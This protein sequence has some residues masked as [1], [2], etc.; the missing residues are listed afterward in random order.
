MSIL[1]KSIDSGSSYFVKL[2]ILVITKDNDFRQ[3]IK[4]ILEHQYSRGDL[5]ITDEFKE[6]INKFKQTQF[7]LVI[8]QAGQN[9]LN[10]ARFCKEIRDGRIG[11]HPFPIVCFYLTRPTP[12][13]MQNVIDCGP[14]DIL[15]MPLVA[16][17]LL[18]RLDGLAR[19]RLPFVVTRNYTGPTRRKENPPG[20]EVI[21][22]IEPPNPLA[23]KI[24]R[25]SELALTKEIDAAS[26][27][28]S[29]LK[30]Q[31]QGVQLNWLAKTIYETVYR[32]GGTDSTVLA[33][34][35]E[36]KNVSQKLYNDTAQWR[37]STISD[38]TKA[39]NDIAKAIQTARGDFDVT[40][41]T[42]LV[43]VTER[44]QAEIN[45]VNG[46]SGQ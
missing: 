19:S 26:Q 41:L 1:K 34:V 7:D 32:I 12:E 40:L 24:K 9:D 16:S 33:N 39:L 44:I 42:D 17:H 3:E 21:P 6:A 18:T 45:R 29:Q 2:S 4:S 25:L 27:R 23:A 31:R 37:R 14:D 8:L 46:L 30:F 38:D 36:I 28:I 15:K 35:E 5:A 10:Y 43:D 13:F 22:E 20:A 11:S